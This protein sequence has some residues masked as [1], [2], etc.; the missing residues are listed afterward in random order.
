ML[1]R[2]GTKPGIRAVKRGKWKLIEWD[3][4]DGSVRKTQLFDLEQNPLELL[5]E[6]QDPATVQLIG[7]QPLPRQRNLAEDPEYEEK[8]AEMREILHA[9]MRRLDDPWRLWNQPKAR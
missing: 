5:E 2:S 1:F 7:N 6:H 4:L 8:L 3:V 9:E